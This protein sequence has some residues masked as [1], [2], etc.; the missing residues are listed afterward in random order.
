MC[1]TLK[2]LT[3]NPKLAG[4]FIFKGGTSLSKAYRV[5]DRFSE[6]IDL[7]IARTA[8]E[9]R[10][11]ESPM[12]SNI[13]RNERERRLDTLK[14]VAQ[15][16]V[17]ETIMPAL[18]KETRAALGTTEGWSIDLDPEDADKQTL[19]FNY[20][21]LANYGL[22]W[23]GGTWDGGAWGEGT[24]GYIKPRIKLEFGARGETD[25]SEQK[26]ITP[27]LAEDFP[28]DL[29]DALVSIPTLSVLRT[30]WEKATILHALHHN[31]KLRAGM[32]R[33]YYDT[34]MLGRRGFADQA[35]AQPDLLDRVV[36]N[37]SLM[38]ADKSASYDTAALGSLC[39]IPTAKT[40]VNLKQ[41]YSAMSEMFMAERPSFDELFSGLR[42]LEKRLNNK[43]G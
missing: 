36:K 41:D 29:R 42:D 12:E 38:F 9:I 15:K 21:R 1:W 11:V 30:F 32:S 26:T 14:K 40:L 7:I 35:L 10:D 18:E 33:H 25:P 8:P 23:S 3:R 31:G 19:L 28:D 39:L 27:Y 24:I 4:Q 34:L 20:P 22:G 17:A 16:Y 37:K 43:P 2:R 6:D 13:G 5:I